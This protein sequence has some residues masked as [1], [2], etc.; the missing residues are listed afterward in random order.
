VPGVVAHRRVATKKILKD[1]K[2][3]T[4]PL[5]EQLTIDAAQL[6]SSGEA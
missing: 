6:M 2:G 3:Y 5:I 1:T 4:N